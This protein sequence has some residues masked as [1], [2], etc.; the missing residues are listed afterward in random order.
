MSV[1]GGSFTLFLT[2]FLCIR[3]IKG[4]VTTQ[5]AIPYE[6]VVFWGSAQ[7]NTEH[8]KGEDLNASWRVLSDVPRSA[9]ALNV[10]SI[11]YGPIELSDDELFPYYDDHIIIANKP[12]GMLSVPGRDIKDSIASRAAVRFG[13]E[14][15]DKLICHRLDMMTSGIIVLA[16]TD[17]AQKSLHKQFREKSVRKRYQAIVSGSIPCS[18]GQIDLPL[19][20]DVAN[21]P[22]QRVDTEGGKPAL[23][24]WAVVGRE[25]WRGAGRK[26]AG[27]APPAATAT[28]AAA[29]VTRV[30]LEPVTGRSHQLRIHMESIGYPILGDNFYGTECTRDM[31]DRLLLHAYSIS[32]EHPWTEEPVQAISKCPF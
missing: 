25:L 2:I 31:S 4:F 13:H 24:E 7:A 14:R 26:G 22:K 32:F 5:T 19:A 29:A 16:R 12:S 20:L 10:P 18:E 23:T 27:G 30:E 21:R 3:C 17:M 28:A 8:S 6:A 1:Q 9:A 11:P 15:I